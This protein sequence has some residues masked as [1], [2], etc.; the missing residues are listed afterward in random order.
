MQPKIK[1]SDFCLKQA[2]VFLVLAMKGTKKYF[3]LLCG[4]FWWDSIAMR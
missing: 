4:T 1:S 2:S 3:N